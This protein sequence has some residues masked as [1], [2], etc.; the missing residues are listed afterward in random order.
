M[1]DLV[2]LSAV[3]LSNLIR[4]RKVSCVEVL[5]AYLQQIS[6][7]NPQ[8]NAVVA[9]DEERARRQARKADDALARGEVWGQLHG[10]PIT[11]KDCFETAGLR[12]T[13]SYLPLAEYTPK[14]DASVV[15]R[16]RAAGA[17]I[18]GKTNLPPMASGA[19]TISPLF[20]VTNNPWNLERTVGGS[21]GGSAAA[22]AAGF[23]AFDIGS[24]MGGSLRLPAH[25]CG[26]F[27]LKPT[28]YLVPWSGHIPPLPGSNGR[29]MRYLLSVGPI[30]RSVDDLHLV[31]TIIAG[32]D[33][34]QWELPPVPLNPV[35]RRPLREMR[36]AWSDSFGT[37]PL[38]AELRTGL[39]QLAGKLESLGCHVERRDPPGFDYALA[40]Q[41]RQEIQ[42]TS[43]YAKAP[44]FNLPRSFFRGLA[45]LVGNDSPITY[46]YLRGAGAD[47][48][49]YARSLSRRD[50]LIS[51][52][53]SFLADYDAWLV[54]VACTEA[55][56]HL[57]LI[58]PWQ[59]SKAELDING[60]KVSYLLATCTFADPF[61]VT[62][63]PVVVLPIGR[64]LEG[65]PFGIQV[66]GRR[67]RDMELLA[68]AEVLAEFTG[69]FQKPPGY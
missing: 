40:T 16:L 34:K 15:S 50:A 47:L 65:L 36:F 37:A 30:A 2:F 49:Q 39:Q 45:H 66:V 56:P 27:S 33:E 18:L 13:C 46:G 55:F 67:W 32:P 12:T 53:E 38:A 58:S 23:S 19:Q 62:G 51:A 54:P 5:E 1:S 42:V 24:D 25:F 64:T 3:Q 57:G 17:I 22:V 26:V 44:P 68:V 43:Q 8:V 52:L 21:S 61:N 48:A 59:Q 60:S 11:I 4:K 9:L 41:T 14:R 20:G 6:Q 10:L 35:P 63:S 7:H 31:L 29:L 69:A 28:D